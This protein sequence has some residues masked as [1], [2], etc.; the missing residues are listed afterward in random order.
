MVSFK[1]ALALMVVAFAVVSVEGQVRGCYFQDGAQKRP[2][3]GAFTGNSKYKWGLCSH[4]FFAFA[5]ITTGSNPGITGNTAGYGTV[6]AFREYNPSMKTIISV[7]GAN[8]VAGFNWLANNQGSIS[9]WAKNAV[10]HVKSNGFY[11]IDLD[12]EYPAGATQKTA[13]TN[14]IK[15]LRSAGGSDFIITFAGSYSKNNL[16]NTYDLGAIKDAVSFINVMTYDYHGDARDKTLSNSPM[17]NGYFGWIEWTID[18]Y[19]AAVS[20]N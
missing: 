8:S 11:G 17:H 5:Q 14:M 4:V 6:K 1:T 19:L 15:A 12:W 7:G 9:T 16:A 2:G 3:V 20:L 18:A 10:A 13:F